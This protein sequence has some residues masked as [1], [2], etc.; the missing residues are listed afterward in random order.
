[1]AKRAANGDGSIYQRKDGRWEASSFQKT[2]SGKVKRYRVVHRERDTARRLL[3]ERIAD[4]LKG[5]PLAEKRWQTGAFLDHWLVERVSRRNR[6]RTVELYEGIIRLHLK[7]FLATTALTDLRRAQVQAMFDDMHD[8]GRSARVIQQS[9]QVLRAALNDAIRQ[10][11]IH[12]NP[13]TA[14]DLPRW[15][16]KTITPWDADQT[17]AFLETAERSPWYGAYL[18]MAMYGLR[19]GEALGLQWGD[20]DF[21]ENSIHVERQLQRVNGVLELGPLKTSAGRRQLPLTGP[22]QAYF[23]NRALTAGIVPDAAH[24]RPQTPRDARL[25]FTAETGGPVDPKTFYIKFKRLAAMAALPDNTLHHL[26]HGAATFMKN[27]GLPAR[28]V[29][30]ILGHAH[31]TTTQQIYQHADEAGQTTALDSIGQ[32]LVEADGSRCRQNYPSNDSQDIESEDLQ[33]TQNRRSTGVESADLRGGPGGARTLDTLLKRLMISRITGAAT[34]VYLAARRSLISYEL[35]AVAV[36]TIRQDR[37][38]WRIY[39]ARWCVPEVGHVNWCRFWWPD[40]TTRLRRQFNAAFRPEP[41]GWRPPREYTHRTRNVRS[42]S[43]IHIGTQRSLRP[44]HQSRQHDKEIG[45]IDG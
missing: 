12:D 33:T 13:A 24:K 19:R 2:T 9:R 37:L 5:R 43:R 6:P 44:S 39:C 22:A 20:F 11:L 17:K 7:P 8:T 38:Q 1:M 27:Q 4:D 16:R 30:L 28:D 45:G 31:I 32:S 34:P 21:A 23:A 40:D 26:R 36:K 41:A 18:L 10:G 25:V 35:A 29:Q 15:E 3:T 14:V 42:S